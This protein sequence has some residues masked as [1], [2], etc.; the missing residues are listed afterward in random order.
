MLQLNCARLILKFLEN[1]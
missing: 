1:I